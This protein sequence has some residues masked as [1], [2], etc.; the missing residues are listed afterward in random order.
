MDVH[1]IGSGHSPSRC[2]TAYPESYFVAFPNEARSTAAEADRRDLAELRKLHAHRIDIV[3]S[4]FHTRRA[5]N[6]Y[7]A[8]APDLEIHVV[9]APDLYFS[10]ATDGGRIEKAAR[11]FCW[12]GR[13]PSPPGSE[14][15]DLKT[16]RNHLK[17]AGPYLWRYRRGMALGMGA[18][19]MKDLLA[20][21]LPLVIRSGV[22][23]LTRGFRIALVFEFAGALGSPLAR[24]RHFPILDARDPDRHLARHR[25]R[26]AQR[27][28][29]PPRRRFPP[30]FYAR[31]RT[32]DIMARATNDLN[33]VRMMLGPGI[34]YWTET[35]FTAVLSIAVML[36]VDWRLTLI[37]PDSRAAGQRWR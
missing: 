7:R 23:S 25:V 8:Q 26:S 10:A 21:A 3:T 13:R 35:M 29:L 14:C 22:D 15:S 18:L 32:G 30:D 37:S 24:Q 2:S 11:L 16:M 20:A 9:A 19:L 33:A 31:Y 28:V 17:T 4:N 6:I 34:M 1:E 5:G 27:S 36:S 12:N